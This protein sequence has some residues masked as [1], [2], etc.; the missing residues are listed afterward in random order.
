L[1]KIYGVYRSRA[2]WVIWAAL[3]LDVPFEHVPII[4]AYRIEYFGIP[5]TLPHSMSDQFLDINMNG[6]V[7]AVID[8]N[9]VLNQS[10][11]INLYLAKKN[12]GPLAPANL[13][14]DA[15]MS[16]WTHWVAT[17]VE[18]AAADILHHRLTYPEQRKRPEIGDQA[19]ATLRRPFAVLN[20]ALSNTPWIVG[21]RFTV[22]DLNLAA[23][24]QC[25]SSAP[26]LFSEAPQIGAWLSRCHSRPAYQE[27]LRRRDAQPDWTK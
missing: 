7:P 14:E 16:M 6:K 5:E 12:G 3:E 18:P 11:T 23:V 2:A 1:L 20:K 19:V 22:A 15:Q 27:L 26:E 8:G 4:P 17:E 13:T 25:T 21:D 10:L 9:L 24:V